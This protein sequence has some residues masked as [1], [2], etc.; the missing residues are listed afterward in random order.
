MPPRTPAELAVMATAIEDFLCTAPDPFIGSIRD[1]F[2]VQDI[3]DLIIE[4][5]EYDSKLKSN[6]VCNVVKQ[7]QSLIKPHVTKSWVDAVITALPILAPP[8]I[9]PKDRDMDAVLPG[10]I[11]WH[12]K[13]DQCTQCRSIKKRDKC[14]TRKN[15][16]KCTYCKHRKQRCHGYKGY[17]ELAKVTPN[18]KRKAAS[19]SST[20]AGKQVDV[21]ASSDES[22]EESESDDASD[23]AIHVAKRLRLDTAAGTSIDETS[24]AGAAAPRPPP[25]PLDGTPKTRVQT[26]GQPKRTGPMAASQASSIRTTPTPTAPVRSLTEPAAPVQPAPAVCTRPALPEPARSQPDPAVAEQTAPAS[27]RTALPPPV[28]S[29]N[30][31]A[32]PQQPAPLRTRSAMDASAR[33]QTEPALAEQPAPVRTRP[34]MA[35]SAQ[36]QTEPAA[37]VISMIEKTTSATTGRA[38]PAPVL[39]ITEQPAHVLVSSDQDDGGSTPT[40]QPLN[41]DAGS[42]PADAPTTTSAR[43]VQA[44]TMTRHAPT[45]PSIAGNPALQRALAHVSVPPFAHAPLFSHGD[46]QWDALD[47]LGNPIA[48]LRDVRITRD[49][50]NDIGSRV[51]TL[52]SVIQHLND[53][54]SAQLQ[55]YGIPPHL[56]NHH[57]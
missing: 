20:R 5:M 31:T 30:E 29:Q 32:A 14:I 51:H 52:Q 53:L 11:V 27:T 13:K 10:D 3:A 35:A 48:V 34:A 46:P 7:L 38:L 50:M 12:D 15:A 25:M 18:R 42:P 28:H 8:E 16:K 6:K 19:P 41:T 36:S 21:G 45:P 9:S 43:D 2:W 33:S 24:A 44:R 47:G 40:A 23:A 56:R 55:A 22:T 39:S 49:I 37:P 54:Q 17:Q 57:V 1:G 26:R 4:Y